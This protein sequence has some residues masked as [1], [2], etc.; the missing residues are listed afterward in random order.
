VALAAGAVLAQSVDVGS[1]SPTD[2]VKATF[3]DAWLRNGFNQLVGDPTGNVAPF[4]STG[5]IQRFPSAGADGGTLALVKPDTSERY[6]VVQ[7]HPAM[8]AYYNSVG[9]SSAGYP[10][11]DTRPCPALKTAAQSANTCQ[12]QQFSANYALFTFTSAVTPGG[13]LN[14]AVRDPYFTRWT[15]SGGIT[16][17]GPAL[18]AETAVTSPAATK[19]TVQKFDQGAIYSITSGVLNGRQFSVKEPVYDLYLSYGSDQGSLGLPTGDELNLANGLRRQTFEAGAIDYD[20]GTGIAVL[21]PP[22]SRVSLAPAGSIQMTAGDTITARVTLYGTDGGTLTDRTVAW[23]TSNGRVAQIQANGFTATIRAVGAGSAVITATAEGKTSAALNVSVTAICCQIGEGAPTAS[24][25]QAFQDAVTRNRLSVQ[26]PA[27]FPAARTGNG[28]AQQLIGSGTPAIPYLVT[29]QDG[30]VAGYVVGGDLLAAYNNL[31]GPAGQLGYPVSDAT[32]GGRQLFQQG[33]LAGKPV[34]LVTGAILAKWS[35][36]GYETGIAGSPNAAAAGFTSFRG[37]AGTMQQFEGALLVAS[38]SGPAYAV[39]GIILAKYGGPNGELGAPTSDERTAGAV[40]QQDF[41]GGTISF[42]PGSAEATVSLKPRQPLVT[43]APASVVSGS[44]VRLAIGGFANGAIVRVSQ[45]GQAD[46]VVA[47]ANGSFTW[48]VRIPANASN[49]TVTVRASEV[50]GANSAQASYTVRNA[51]SAA[52]SISIVSGDAQTGAPGA[53]L[54]QPLVVVVKDTSGNPAP[55]QTVTFAASAGAQ[56]VPATAVTDDAG[57]ASAELRMAPGAG[58]VLA[59]AAAAHD[60]VTFSA[61][62]AAVS[63]TG[64]PAP[65]QDVEGALGNGSDPIRQKGALLASAAAILRYH[66]LRGELTQPFGLADALSLNQFLKSFCVAGTQLCDGF[67]STGGEQILNLWRLGAF[68]TG[69]VDVRVEPPDVSAVRDLVAAGS[70]VLLV[71]S[72]TGRGPHFVV[73]KGI[74]ADGSLDIADP[75]PSFSQGATATMTGAVRLLPQAPSTAGFLIT[76]SADSAV[77]NRAG[78]CGRTLQFSSSLYFRYCDGS[79]GPYEWDI[80]ASAG[81][82]FTDLSAGGA[83]RVL[84]GAAPVSFEIVRDG[85]QWTLRG[86]APRIDDPGGVLDA[87]SFGVAVAPGG[88]VSVFGAGL[89]GARAEV[90]G[91]AASVL[92]ALPFQVNVQIPFEA[93]PGPATIKLISG[94]ASAQ[95]GFTI[96]EVAPAIFSIGPRQ[97]AI[98]NQDSTLNTGSNPALRGSYIVIY[99]TGLGA[100]T[101]SGSLSRASAPVSA[102]IGGTEVAAAFAG[103]T[104]GLIGLYQ[105]NVLVPIGLPPGLSL[106]L[107]LKQGSAVSNTVTVAIQ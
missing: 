65:S 85:P 53:R 90:N 5:L 17:L 63:L 12:W 71:L 55:R 75:N 30:S 68:V 47:L 21:R 4:G 60:V 16:G 62:A 99:G 64:F 104:P 61:R 50:N 38:G 66:Q 6:N 22:V 78:T 82:S 49:G 84:D 20:P 40:R 72:L 74:A 69:T 44:L 43:A 25:R 94:E 80:A 42:A 46:F 7:V 26:L 2:G 8:L 73:A 14:L 45:T 39:T 23:N 18:S 19:A 67:I 1:G 93:P 58:I 106:P 81:A 96:R 33:A 97:A 36:L 89:A 87:A 48:D 10:V 59:T 92:A 107:Y 15:S 76:A 101:R 86:L 34:Q 41:E 56:I 51:A 27:A 28:Y 32:G 24:I 52:L 100:V 13:P 102:V 57:R 31:G 70:P 29:V 9:V 11:N 88:I 98:T 103:L 91:A 105:A 79:G 37:T 77:A 54:A 3:V 83:R 95:Q 35:S